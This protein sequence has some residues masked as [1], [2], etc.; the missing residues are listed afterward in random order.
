MFYF[1]AAFA[2]DIADKHLWFLVSLRRFN[3]FHYT[4]HQGRGIQPPF[5]CC[6]TRPYL[7]S[8]NTKGK[9]KQK[10]LFLRSKERTTEA[11]R[12]PAHA[13][14]CPHSSL[15]CVTQLSSTMILL[16][17]LSCC[18]RLFPDSIL[19]PL[20]PSLHLNTQGIYQE[21]CF[22]RLAEQKVT[23][24]NKAARLTLLPSPHYAKVQEHKGSQS[25]NPAHSIYSCSPN[26]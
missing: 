16:R 26:N 23:G 15:D 18:L 22:Q 8:Y 21:L 2:P 3:G 19:K 1:N 13:Y 17:M 10:L 6:L 7:K 9:E 14:Y 4:P 5:Q 20:E 11:W 12:D 24:A 25:T